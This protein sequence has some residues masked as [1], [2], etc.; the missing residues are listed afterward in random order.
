MAKSTRTNPASRGGLTLIEDDAVDESRESAPAR[1]NLADSNASARLPED[2]I[3]RLRP[4]RPAETDPEDEPFLRVRRRVPVRRGVI[5]GWARTRWGR[6]LFIALILAVFAAAITLA[7]AVRTFFLRNAQFRIDSTNAIQTVGNNEVS[8]AA[9]LSV[10]GSDIGRDIFFVPLTQ[11]RAQL[12]RMP[13]V[14]NA[15]VMRILP[16]HL[17][18]FLVERQP[19]AFLQTGSTISL[20]DAQGMVLA[21]TPQ[22]MARDHFNFPVITGL[23][24][25][26]PM[27]MRAA[28]IQLYLKFMQTLQNMGK[29]ITSHISEVDLSDPEDVRATITENG[30]DLLLHF[31]QQHFRARYKLYA[32]NIQSWLS[33]YPALSA[34]D[35]RYNHQVVLTMAHSVPSTAGD[36]AGADPGLHQ[37][38]T[39]RPA[40]PAQRGRR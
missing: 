25:R 35:L 13:W 4:F 29:N 8:R 36:A 26:I 40:H 2:A 19:V 14:K 5:P 24:P 9:I 1:R 6:I 27:P 17:R 33:Q 21:L 32:A 39:T 7:L 15:T 11:R 16:N 12:E 37:K 31:G 3:P 28:R 38:L 20:I 30:R 23:D 18:V 34:V 10:F 22:I